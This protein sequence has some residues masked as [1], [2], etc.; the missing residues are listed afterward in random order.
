[1][2]NSLQT[3]SFLF[4]LVHFRQLNYSGALFGAESLAVC[5][6]ESLSMLDLK[7]F[8]YA[9]C[10]QALSELSANDSVA[11]EPYWLVKSSMN[12]TRQ[13]RH[14][15]SKCVA[16]LLRTSG[17]LKQHV[18]LT[19][20]NT[21]DSFG[22]RF[23][24]SSSCSSLSI[25]QQQELV[26]VLELIRL[27]SASVKLA[28]APFKLDLNVVVKICKYLHSLMQ[29]LSQQRQSSA[30]PQLSDDCIEVA[31]RSWCS[32]GDGVEPEYTPLEKLECVE[33]YARVYWQYV[34]SQL[35]KLKQQRICDTADYDYGQDEDEYEAA[36]EEDR[37]DR[38]DE[39]LGREERSNQ[40]KNERAKDNEENEE[41]Y[42]IISREEC[43]SFE[44]P[45]Q[46]LNSQARSQPQSQPQPQS[47]SQRS[48]NYFSINRANMSLLELVE[49]DHDKKHY[50]STKARGSRRLQMR[51]MHE[52]MDI[53]AEK[54]LLLL[55]GECI[56]RVAAART[57]NGNQKNS[58]DDSDGGYI[59]HSF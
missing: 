21:T 7:L 20:A 4:S 56:R 42:C 25:K 36:D 54:G 35:I 48:E 45:P 24:S 41:D 28:V 32:P 37:E 6:L 49:N 12:L 22:A 9:A 26:R 29:T 31:T 43:C 3:N 8:M 23:D 52:R 50:S 16:Y 30:S 44:D 2:I 27:K 13:Q 40:S 51:Q 19:L 34:C 5:T 59:F 53:L 18:D 57:S 11:L 58:S 38:E 17:Y 33:R 14:W 47:Q 1:L 10:M 15:W 55:A 46:Q 39:R